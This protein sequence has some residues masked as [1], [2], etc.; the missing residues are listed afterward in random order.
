MQE[1]S[2]FNKGLCLGCVGLAEKDWTGPE[3]CSRYKQLNN[4]SG[5]ELCKKILKE[6]EQM[7][8]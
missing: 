3:R 7:R 2:V 8:L 5:I 4:T 6:G 1:C